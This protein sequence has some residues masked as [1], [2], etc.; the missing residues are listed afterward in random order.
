MVQQILGVANELAFRAQ[1]EALTKRI[2]STLIQRCRIE[3]DTGVA[4]FDLVGGEFVAP[5]RRVPDAGVRGAGRD[6]TIDECEPLC[7]VAA[8][9]DEQGGEVLQ[10]LDV[11]WIQFER[12]AGEFDTCRHIARGVMPKC[13]R[14]ERARF[15]LRRQRDPSTSFSACCSS[16]TRN[17]LVRT[18]PWLLTASATRVIVSSSGASAMMT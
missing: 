7:V 16:N 3:I 15:L 6:R 9:R 2:G 12:P 11:L 4:S 18:L 1:G 13:I 14:E 10:R 5:A 8:A 17:E